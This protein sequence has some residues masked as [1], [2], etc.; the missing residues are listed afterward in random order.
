MGVRLICETSGFTHIVE[1]STCG[2]L[3]GHLSKT[4]F[5]HLVL[6]INFSDGN[7]IEFIPVI[8][9]L[10]PELRILVFSTQPTEVHGNALRQFKIHNYL[11]KENSY[12]DTIR[13][14]RQFLR[15]EQPARV[16]PQNEPP[17]SPFSKLTPRQ[18]EI[19]HYMLKGLGTKAIAQTLNVSMN[20]ISTTKN[21]IYEKTQTSNI[22]ELLELAKL[23]SIS[24]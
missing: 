18:L 24:H 11:N 8:R 22:M 14:I 12:E 3:M 2:E 6:D 21:R 13:Q 20:T 10:Y 5:T 9:E 7:A 4:S 15:N 16:F 1:A 19:L 17:A 23:S